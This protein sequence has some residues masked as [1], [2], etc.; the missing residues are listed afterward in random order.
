[1]VAPMTTTGRAVPRVRAALGR[2]L[3]AMRRER[4]L[5]QQALGTDAGLSAK[6]IGEVERGQKSI[7]VDSLARVATAL[8]VR[9]HELLEFD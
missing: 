3:I 9:L 2:R 8:G 5:S 7:S 4:D 6:F 1:M